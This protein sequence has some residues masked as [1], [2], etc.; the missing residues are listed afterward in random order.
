MVCDEN[1]F[2][3]E[4]IIFGENMFFD[5]NTVFG[6]NIY[7]LKCLGKIMAYLMSFFSQTL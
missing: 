7:G 4:N 2:F 6:E 5:E 3:G 1:T